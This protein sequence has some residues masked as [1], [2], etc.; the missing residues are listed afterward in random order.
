MQF[1]NKFELQDFIVEMLQ[2]KMG[3]QTEDVYGECNESTG[4]A[5]IIIEFKNGDTATLKLD[6]KDKD[7][8]TK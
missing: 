4:R 1:K 8:N 7:L 5:D 3:E 2:E 6:M